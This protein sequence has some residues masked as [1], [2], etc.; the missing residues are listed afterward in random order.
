MFEVHQPA[1]EVSRVTGHPAGRVSA[2]FR[3]GFLACK[4]AGYA[5]SL[6]VEQAAHTLWAGM[7]GTISLHHSMLRDDSTETLTLQ[8]ADGLLTS[9]VAAAPGTS[10]PFPTATA[11]TAASRHIRDILTGGQRTD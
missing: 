10:P 5:L 11:E 8:M 2:A 9:L 1:V 6:P 7:H 3:A 4:E